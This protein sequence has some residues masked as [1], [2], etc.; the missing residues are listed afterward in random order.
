M[1]VYEDHSVVI[2]GQDH[3]F[4]NILNKEFRVSADSFFQVNTKMAEKMVEHILTL[5][6]VPNPPPSSTFTAALASSANSS[7][8]NTKKSSASNHPIRLRRFR[9][10]PRR[11]RQRGTIRRPAEESCPRSSA[12][13]TQPT[14]SSTRP[15]Q[16]LKSTPSTPSST[17]NRRSSPM[18]H[19]T[20]PHWRATRHDLSTAAIVW[21]KQ[22]PSTS[23]PKPITSNQFHFSKL[24]KKIN[25]KHPESHKRDKKGGG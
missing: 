7:H 24:F 6:P 19:A 10:Q 18:F 21:W 12:Q 5:L 9:L 11:I 3:F 16:A 15:A 14:R 1:H 8:Q 2:A 13:I 17:S 22:L 25:M 4:V 23:S 20:H